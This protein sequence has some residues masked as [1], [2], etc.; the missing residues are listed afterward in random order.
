VSQVQ[1]PPKVVFYQLGRKF[2]DEKDAAPA[3][4]TQVVYYSLAIGH[5]VG[6]IDCLHPVL[7]CPLGDFAAW[8]ERWP[9]GE[10]RSKLEG[11]HRFGE[12]TIDA[13]HVAMLAAALSEVRTGGTPEELHWAEC[14]EQSLQVIKA[15]PAVYLIGRRRP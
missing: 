14:L 6:V 4:A 1:S 12:I 2:L 8:L 3:Q 7:D 15:E 5:H 10:A 11:L 13:S 9:Q